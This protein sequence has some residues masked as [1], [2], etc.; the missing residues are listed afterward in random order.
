M[1]DDAIVVKDLTKKFGNF[2]AVDH[3]NFSVK[4]GELFGFL[5]PN[6]AG[7]STTDFMLTTILPPTSGTAIINGFDIITDSEKVR[8]SIGI[9]FQDQ[10][11]DNRLTA[12]DNLDIHGRLYGM[13]SGDR[14]QKIKEVLQ[15]VEL[16]DWEQK[17]VKT[18]S[19]GMRRRLEIARGLMHQPQILFLD[20]PTL[21]LDAQTRRHMW[22]YIEKLREQRI[23]IVLSTHYLEEADALCDRI[24][25]ID[26]GKIVALDTP[27][28]L[29]SLIGGQVL[30][31]KTSDSKK[32]LSILEKQKIG[33]HGRILD[34]AVLVEVQNGSTLIAKV[35]SL[36]E[37]SGVVIENIELH[38]PSLED[39]FL[40]LTGE[41]IR[42]ERPGP[43][44]FQR[45]MN[46]GH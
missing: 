33:S 1:T 41:Q 9:V 32:M 8:K 12:Y 17:L 30:S 44:E 10:T 14:K 21:G 16:A 3:I 26:R 29:K 22:K 38:T 42:D 18:F 24:A 20:E 5:G 43:N 40:K 35:V 37:K 39:V 19:G 6:G 11:L 13:S 46:H 34:R 7:K 36:A 25:I 31:L 28:K 4:K 2:T 15:L 23:T 45:R 27:Q